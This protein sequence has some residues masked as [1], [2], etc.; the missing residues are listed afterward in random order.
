MTVLTGTAM[1]PSLAAPQ[2]A[3]TKAGESSS[4]SSTRSSTST[5]SVAN[6]LAARLT[7]SATS[8]QVI[9]WPACRKA[10]ALPRPSLTWRS[11]KKVAALKLTASSYYRTRCRRS[12]AD[13]TPASALRLSVAV[14]TI[15]TKA[16]RINRQ[17]ARNATAPELMT[18]SFNQRL[19]YMKDDV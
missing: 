17:R 1:A 19:L 13:Q 5:P 10:A 12:D 15:A 7:R 6:A 4:A 9:V 18:N 11:T 2:N 16:P 14:D 8:A 3:A